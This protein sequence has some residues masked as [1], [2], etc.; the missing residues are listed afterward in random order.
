M[1]LSF[2]QIGIFDNT[3]WLCLSPH[4]YDKQMTKHACEMALASDIQK[5]TFKMALGPCK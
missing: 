1:F 2:A 5:N 3:I 4:T